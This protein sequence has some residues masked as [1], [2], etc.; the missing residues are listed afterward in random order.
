METPQRKPWEIDHVGH[1]VKDLVEAEDFYCKTMGYSVEERES[2]DDQR[3]EVVFLRGPNGLIEL[4]AP[5]PGNQNLQRFLSSRG[6]GLHHICFWVPSVEEELKRLKEQGVKLIDQAPRPGSR[7]L[8]VAF[9]HP[10]SCEGVLVEICS[11]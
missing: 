10:S 3:V 1:V 8:Q 4:L 5:L 2:L 6:P 11:E 7:G 9:L